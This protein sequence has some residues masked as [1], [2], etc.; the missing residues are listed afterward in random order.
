MSNELLYDYNKDEIKNSLTIE[1]VTEYIAEL[2]G[3]PNPLPDIILCKTICHGGD[4]H[5]LY[6]YDNTKLFKCYT[7]GCSADGSDAFD[8]FE[9]TRKVMSREKPKEEL[10]KEGNSMPRDWNLPEAIDYVAQFFGFSPVEKERNESFIS[11]DTW[12]ILN[13]YDRINNIDL[14]TKIVELKVY[15][16]SILKYMPIL[17]I[18]PWIKEGIDFKVM[19]DR[20]IC[21][22]PKSCGIIIPHYDIDNK[23]VGIRERTLILENEEKGKYRPA[24]INKQLYNH[25]LSFNLYNLNNSK[26]NIK[27]IKKVFVFE[28]E[29]SCLQYASFFGI[30]NDISVAC[31]GSSF[32]QYQAWLLMELGVEEIIVGFDKQFQEKGDKEFKKLIKNLT[33]I[34]KKYGHLVKISYLFDKEDLLGYKESPTDRGKEVFEKLYKNRI[35]LYI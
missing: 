3:E 6:Y 11:A 7:G 30:E 2:G 1:Q 28:S 4:S 25:P 15:D 32:I 8:I 33:T 5:K 34:F 18:Q 16:E 31:C 24:Y 23:L 14:N 12:K 17:P 20:G 26:D 9:L 21:F 10:T 13:N 22:N 19:K 35:N 27:N 29:K